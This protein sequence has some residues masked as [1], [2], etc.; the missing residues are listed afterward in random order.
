MIK[1]IFSLK[2]TFLMFLALACTASS[3]SDSPAQESAEKDEKSLEKV[4]QVISSKKI[5]KGDFKQNKLIKRL[6]REMASEG[7]FIISAEDGILWETER[8]Y[9]SAMAMT[10]SAIIQTNAKGKKTVLSSNSNATFEQFA[11]VLSSVFTGNSNSLLEN[12]EVEF[13]GTTDN[14]N[15]N[16]KP[17]NSTVKNF[18]SEIEMAGK[19]SIDRMT[20]HEPNGDF[21]RYE[22]M[23]HIYPEN[24][25]D[26]EKSYFKP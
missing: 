8:P 14:W 17:K 7:V 11:T 2:K 1:E 18:V 22:F 13:V 4:C 3:F 16:L 10:K 21:V 24:L 9:Y 5:T 19:I 20:I 15:I 25:T 23:N 26:E 6:K 12:F